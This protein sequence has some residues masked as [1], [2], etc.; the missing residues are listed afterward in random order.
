MDDSFSSGDI[1]AVESELSSDPIASDA[2]P[3][4]E[5]ST[6]ATTTAPPAGAIAPPVPPPEAEDVTASTKEP[7]Q[8]RWPAVLE[9]ARTKARAEAEAQFEREYG[10]A[11]QIDRSQLQ[12]WAQV[13]SQMASDPVGFVQ[14]MIG[15]LQQHPHYSQQLRSHAAR[16]LSQRG[17]EEAEP[18]GDIDVLDEHGRPTGTKTYSSS[19]LAKWRDW[20]NRQ[21]LSQVDERFA[22]LKQHMQSEQQ[23]AQEAETQRVVGEYAQKTVE[24]AKSWYGFNEYKPQIKAAMEADPNLSLDQAWRSVLHTQILPR[25]SQTARSQ[26]LADINAKATATTV[27]PQRPQTSTPVSDR[28][29]PIADLVAEEMARAGIG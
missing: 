18:D 15:D 23:R 17:G 27:S 5:S 16:V 8:E 20:N 9:N 1:A 13:A 7:P 25:M 3:A 24:D 26:V 22:P 21:V 6:V 14:R 29:R 12:E 11:K 4:S 28:D 2:P 10:W 19:Q